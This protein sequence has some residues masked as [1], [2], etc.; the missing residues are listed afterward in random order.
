MRL[1]L[2][3][4]FLVTSTVFATPVFIGTGATGIY[5]ADFDAATGKLTEPAMAAEYK[6]PDWIAMHPTKPV[7]YSIG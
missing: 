2:I 3:N 6:S 1:T 5:L 7:L 4:L